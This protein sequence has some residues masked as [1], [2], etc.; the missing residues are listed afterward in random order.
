[1]DLSNKN[2]SKLPDNLP[3]EI[4][5]NFDCSHNKLENLFGSP[6]EVSGSFICDGNRLTSLKGAPKKAESI[7]CN[8]NKLTS[9]KIYFEL[10]GFHRLRFL[11]CS[12]NQ[13]TTLKGLPFRLDFG[14][15]CKNNLLSTLV[16]G[17]SQV[18]GCFY[19]N[20]N[21]LTDLNGAPDLITVSLSVDN[22]NLKSLYGISSFIKFNFWCRFN[23]NLI[24][25]SD[26]WGSSI[27]DTVYINFN[28][29]L[30]ILPLVK[31][32]VMM[33]HSLDDILEKHKGNS[34]QNIANLQYDLFDHGF[35]NN[36][37]WKPES[38]LY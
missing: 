16:G 31:F 35:S 6:S 8:N 1:M 33:D 38:N 22:N 7:S 9:I 2:L 23:E 15:F 10:N 14:L 11:D 36:A 21:N 34:K 26:I 30:A 24:D 32:N 3:Q 28:E 18:N 13:I 5:G 4:V 27:G 29:K 19:V 25:V 12:N 37:K 20:G 17:P